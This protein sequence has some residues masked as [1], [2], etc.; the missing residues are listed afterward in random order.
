MF[1]IGIS[2]LMICC[3]IGCKDKKPEVEVVPEKAVEKDTVPVVEEIPVDT[4]PDS[5][6]DS[7]ISATPMPKAADE[8][9]DDFLFNF[10]ANKKLQYERV[11]FPLPVKDGD[12]EDSIEMKDW[13][14]EKFFMEQEFYTLIFMPTTFFWSAATLRKSFISAAISP[15]LLRYFTRRVSSSSIVPA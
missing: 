3:T 9:F 11:K 5:D 12:S 15:F 13:K 1:L 4:I 7:L 6:R 10:T 14:I 8:L 2:V